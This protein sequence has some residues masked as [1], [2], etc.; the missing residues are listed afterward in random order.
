M[1]FSFTLR[2]ICLVLVLLVSQSLFANDSIYEN[3][4]QAYLN[5]SL[6]NTNDV[7]VIAIQAY[8]TGVVDT[9]LIRTTLNDIPTVSTIDFRIVKLIR[10][11]FLTNGAYDN[12]IYSSLDTLPFWITPNDT[13]RGYW[14]ENHTIMWMSSDWLLHEKFGRAIDTSLHQR[15]VHYLNLKI[16]YGFYEFLSPTYAPFSLSGLVN[17]ADFAQDPQIKDLA[18]KAA[19]ILLRDLLR[20]TND[21]G[22]TFSVAGRAY[23]GNYEGAYSHNHRD[24]M[25]LLTGLGPQPVGVS[26]SPSFLSTSSLEVDSI[27]T[28]FKSEIDTVLNL[29]HSVDS[30][31]IINSVLRPLDKTISQWS[32]GMYFHPKVAFE[33]GTLIVNYNLWHHVDFDDFRDFEN[34]S[35]TDIQ[36]IAD[37]LTAISMSSTNCQSTIAIFKHQNVVLSSI[38]DF[39]KGKVGYQQQP[40]MANV[41]TTS[42]YLGSG[43]VK[44]NW[45]NRPANNANDHL[46]Y[47]EQKHNVALLMY[48]P[49]PN[50]IFLKSKDVALHFND[51]EFDEIRNDS[52]WILGRQENGYVAVRRYCL[53]EKDSVRAC[54]NDRGQSW[55]IVVGDSSMYGSFN[56]F[57]TVITQSQFS[58][59]WYYDSISSQS[60]YHASITVDTITVD[61]AW[62]VDSLINSVNETDGLAA[63]KVYPNPTQNEVTVELNGQ[64]NALVGITVFNMVGQVVYQGETLEAQQRIST[65][66]WPEGLYMIQIEQE[67]NRHVQKLVKSN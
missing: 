63:F 43:T 39:W 36:G 26:H 4:R 12:L 3:R 17:L 44:R 61:Y 8:K 1:P 14:S 16:K 48:R 47:I 37:E 65:A 67:G 20:V 62:G 9:N 64:G 35:P 24:L 31:I 38:Q 28:S 41:G 25:Y 2:G 55:V 15:L 66:T 56:N 45:N 10:V 7:D 18:T 49:E 40:I 33:S 57:E 42:V 46:P 22:V 21:K 6:L 59:E 13:L 58:D 53:G 11:L 54:V 30:S 34:F 51:A 29:G 50:N 27:L 52:L 60:V 23:P 5:S 32:S 19:V